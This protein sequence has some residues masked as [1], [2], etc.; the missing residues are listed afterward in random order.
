MLDKF[1]NGT[2]IPAGVAG[3][4]VE[5]IRVIEVRSSCF[6]FGVAIESLLYDYLTLS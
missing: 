4:A 6:R 1:C 5:L 3:A 2:P